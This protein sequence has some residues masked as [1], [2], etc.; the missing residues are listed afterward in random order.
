[1]LITNQNYLLVDAFPP[2]IKN[3]ILEVHANTYFP[4]P[5]I[6]AS[7]LGAIAAASQNSID[8]ELPLGSVSPVSLAEIKRVPL[9]MRRKSM[10]KDSACPVGE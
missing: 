6:A 8:V 3:A 7:A 10:L 1:M 5:L 9:P 4:I 2:S